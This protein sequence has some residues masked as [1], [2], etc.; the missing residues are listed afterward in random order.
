MA[1]KSED[2]E[3]LRL[4]VG[5]LRFFAHLKQTEFADASG[6][7]QVDISLYESGKQRPREKNLRRM[8]AAA[9]VPWAAV[10]LLR[11]FYGALL[12]VIRAGRDWSRTGT[13]AGEEGF[14]REV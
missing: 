10:W 3:V 11:R 7:Q 8:A 9:G 1:T 14:K 4:L 13:P 2:P 5:F 12:I 6:L